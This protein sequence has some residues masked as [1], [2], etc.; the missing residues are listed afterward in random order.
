MKNKIINEVFNLSLIHGLK[1][2]TVS[3]IA[4][5]LKISKKTIYEYFESKD[6]IIENVIDLYIS[7]NYDQLNQQLQNCSTPIEELKI[8]CYLFLP[9]PYEFYK[10]NKDEIHLFY[11]KRYTQLQELINFKTNKIIDIYKKGISEGLFSEKINPLAI[12]LMAKSFLDKEDTEENLFESFYEILLYG[13][14]KH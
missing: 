14:I 2:L 10:K 6:E 7:K 5:S 1:K 8:C 3:E 12:T 4:A 11:P 9:S 13:C